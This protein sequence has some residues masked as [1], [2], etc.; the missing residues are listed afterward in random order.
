M[1]KPRK[2]NNLSRTGVAP[3]SHNGG[4]KGGVKRSPKPMVPAQA[5]HP[6]RRHD[7]IKL[8]VNEFLVVSPEGKAKVVVKG[9]EGKTKKS[10]VLTRQQKG[11]LGWE[12]MKKDIADSYRKTKGWVAGAELKAAEDLYK[13]V[14]TRAKQK[15]SNVLVEMRNMG[16]EYI[17]QYSAKPK[18]NA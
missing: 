7:M 6:A 15:G 8:K 9:A 14:R 11:N 12:L 1:P 10:Y 16:I 3:G 13:I 18:G 2:K 5:K 17:D 4:S